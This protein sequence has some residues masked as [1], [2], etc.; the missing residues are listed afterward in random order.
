[1]LMNHT[2][3]QIIRII[4]IVDLNLFAVHPDRTAGGLIQAEQNTHQG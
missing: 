1:M 2:D 3:V 4:R